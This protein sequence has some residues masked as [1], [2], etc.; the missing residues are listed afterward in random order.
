MNNLI[1]MKKIFI[2][3]NLFFLFSNQQKLIR[4]YDLIKKT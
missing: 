2:S 1:I 3:K 4:D